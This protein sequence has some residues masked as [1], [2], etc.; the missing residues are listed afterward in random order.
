[1]LCV[2][3]VKVTSFFQICFCNDK[4]YFCLI[5]GNFFRRYSNPSS[6]Y[7]LVPLEPLGMAGSVAQGSSAGINDGGGCRL[8]L[9]KPAESKNIELFKRTVLVLT[10]RFL[11]NN[12]VKL[13]SYFDK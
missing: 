6:P 3:T 8:G 11:R 10:N 7:L 13:K 9:I 1:M 12:M 5:F 4:Q 2:N